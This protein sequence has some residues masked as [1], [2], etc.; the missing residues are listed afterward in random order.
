MSA[1]S[2]SHPI[3]F[4]VCSAMARKQMLIINYIYLIW[5]L[6]KNMELNYFYFKLLPKTLN[7]SNINSADPV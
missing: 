4:Q 7:Y 6:V 5:D 1:H 2:S 3:F